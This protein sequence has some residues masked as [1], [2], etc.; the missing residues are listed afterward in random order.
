MTQGK[1]TSEGRLLRAELGHVNRSK[2][3]KLRV[4]NAVR[5]AGG[6]LVEAALKLGITPRTL[7]AIR[8]EFPELSRAIEGLQ[9]RLGWRRRGPRVDVGSP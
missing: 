6:N 5:F 9:T 7:V 1:P 8:H 3:A 4:L 2:A